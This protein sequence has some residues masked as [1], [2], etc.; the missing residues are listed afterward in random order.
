M[1]TTLLR[2]RST[3]RRWRDNRGN[4]R[5]GIRLCRGKGQGEGGGEG[6]RGWWWREEVLLMWLGQLLMGQRW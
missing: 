5:R 2:T 3:C 4:S 1:S 6:G